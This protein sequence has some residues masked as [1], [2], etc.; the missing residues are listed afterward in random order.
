MSDLI[1]RKDLYEKIAELEADVRKK[2]LSTP[3][4]SEAYIRYV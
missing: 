2:L 4:D 3:R 1:S